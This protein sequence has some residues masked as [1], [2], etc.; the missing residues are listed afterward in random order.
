MSDAP[1]GAGVPGRGPGASAAA[2][3]SASS[4]RGAGGAEARE[5]PVSGRGVGP[6]DVAASAGADVGAEPAADSGDAAP[7]EGSDEE[8]AAATE[9]TQRPVSPDPF[10]FTQVPASS[11]ASYA[12]R[13]VPEEGGKAAVIDEAGIFLGASRP[14]AYPKRADAESAQRDG[15]HV[16]FVS[17]QHARVA[18]ASPGADEVTVV[19]TSSLEGMWIM[20]DDGEQLGRGVRVAARA[21]SVISLGFGSGASAALL[22][23]P[24][25]FRLTIALATEALEVEAVGGGAAA[26][27]A[28]AA[29][30]G[31]G[32][33]P[34]GVVFRADGPALT[35]SAADAGLR[36]SQPVAAVLA[37]AGCDVCR[38]RSEGRAI[39]PA[40]VVHAAPVWGA[41]PSCVSAGRGEPEH[42]RC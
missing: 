17:S 5:S 41:A 7:A 18:L 4:D 31:G 22:H 14:E 32:G 33:A 42:G 30:G 2:A 29:G 37:S 34:L 1:N 23:P 24:V 8:G 9:F 10:C 36:S 39:M 28:G 15:A 35:I 6:S 20:I 19:C 13:A 26:A 27:G 25:C 3:A 38:W 11:E 16:G 40:R 12:L 21:G